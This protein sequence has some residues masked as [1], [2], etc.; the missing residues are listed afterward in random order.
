MESGT[1]ILQK[2]IIDT[3]YRIRKNIKRPDIS[4]IFKALVEDNPTNIDIHSVEKDARNMIKTD[5]WKTGKHAKGYNH[6]LC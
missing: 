6:F 2:S 1:G 4:S 5:F 3:I